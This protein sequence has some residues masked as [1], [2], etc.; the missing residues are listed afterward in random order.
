L[1]DML[2]NRH[3][4]RYESEARQSKRREK[5]G[6]AVVGVEISALVERCCWT[7]CSTA[8][9]LC[10]L[11]NGDLPAQGGSMEVGKE[12]WSCSIC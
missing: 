5:D 6:S 1:K 7:N 3:R 12:R 9:L 2:P 10:F 4:F 11:L 8:S